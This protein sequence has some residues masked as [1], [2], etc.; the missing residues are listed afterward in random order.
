MDSE[1][2]SKLKQTELEGLKSTLSVALEE[3]ETRLAAA[4]ERYQGASHQLEDA[5]ARLVEAD[6]RMEQLRSRAEESQSLES[7]LRHATA[8]AAQ[9]K[10]AL[11]MSQSQI[12]AADA[13]R[14]QAEAR[15]TRAKYGDEEEQ[16]Q[17]RAQLSEAHSA[18]GKWEQEARKSSREAEEVRRILD[19]SQ[20]QV[21]D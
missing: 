6:A 14:S 3:K 1:V 11:Q 21:T 20:Q 9:A 17:L 15:A 16:A 12:S 2:Q 4:A 10:A 8:E 13:Q 7:Q 18:A 5:E 19:A